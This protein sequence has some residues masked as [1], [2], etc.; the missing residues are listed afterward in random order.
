[1]IIILSA[2]E[3]D[4]KKIYIEL[5]EERI[6]MLNTIGSSVMFQEQKDAIHADVKKRKVDNSDLSKRSKPK[7][8]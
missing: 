6:N 5:A 4:K 1:M 3:I 8:N 7:R 2:L